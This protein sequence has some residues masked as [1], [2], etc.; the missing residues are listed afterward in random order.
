MFI[1]LHIDDHFEQTDTQNYTC[2]NI[3]CPPEVQKKAFEYLKKNRLRFVSEDMIKYE[4]AFSISSLKL[5]YLCEPKVIIIKIVY[6]LLL[7]I[8]FL[9][10]LFE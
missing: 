8:S 3:L 7:K 4:N 6:V 9:F 5:K 2:W 10:K 1:L